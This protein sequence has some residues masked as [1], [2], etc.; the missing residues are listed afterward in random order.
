MSGELSNNKT[1]FYQLAAQ[2]NNRADLYIFTV[3]GQLA[4]DGAT[5]GATDIFVIRASGVGQ[6]GKTETSVQSAQFAID[7]TTAGTVTVAHGL[8]YTPQ[9]Y[10]LA[11]SLF[12]SSPSDSTWGMG[13]FRINSCD[14]T[15]VEIGYQVDAVAAA[16]S[17]ARFGLLCK[18]C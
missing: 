5:P 9:R 7:T 18:I 16:G 15:N 11:L 17:L 10:Q 4:V 1:G 2:L 12:E 8:L 3:A 13:Y 6:S 14:A